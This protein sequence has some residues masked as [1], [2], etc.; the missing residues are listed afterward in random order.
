MTI[1][2]YNYPPHRSRRRNLS[3]IN[4]IFALIV[5][6]GGDDKRVLLW[7]VEKS[8]NDK[9]NVQVML[10]QH[11]SNIFC[12]AIDSGNKRIFSGGNDDTAIVHDIET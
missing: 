12:L 7:H 10:K 8:L 5:Y 3:S 11:H 6:T 9:E 4:N 2:D 1:R